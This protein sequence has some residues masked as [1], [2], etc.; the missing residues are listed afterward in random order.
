MRYHIVHSVPGTG[1]LTYAV[2]KLISTLGLINSDSQSVK[3]VFWGRYVNWRPG[4][5]YKVLPF[6]AYVKRILGNDIEE[7]LKDMVIFGPGITQ[8]PEFFDLLP[9]RDEVTRYFILPEAYGS[10]TLDETIERSMYGLKERTNVYKRVE[11]F[12]DAEK[13]ELVTEK[14]RSHIAKFYG[15]VD[16]QDLTF[17]PFSN[18]AITEDNTLTTVG[19]AGVSPSESFTSMKISV[20]KQDPS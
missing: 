11:K 2:S 1:G 12:G 17:S 4:T 15:Y 10:E 5:D 3:Q 20:V 19:T 9:M 14:W 13:L 7:V 18:F 16:K 8:R 6:V